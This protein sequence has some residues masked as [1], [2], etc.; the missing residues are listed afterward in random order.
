MDK[1]IELSLVE[2][3]SQYIRPDG[4]KPGTRVMLSMVTNKKR[5]DPLVYVDGWKILLYP[6]YVRISH[7]DT[8]DHYLP[9][10][11]VKI[12]LGK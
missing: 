6:T 8:W 10:G 3:E 11:Q 5:M 9:L 2:F 12:A 7:T 4:T 1:P